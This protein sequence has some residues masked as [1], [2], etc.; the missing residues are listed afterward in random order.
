METKGFPLNNWQKMFSTD[1]LGDL[2]AYPFQDKDWY[3]K[4]LP[5]TVLYSALMFVLPPAAEVIQKGFAW[6]VAQRML[7]EG[8]EP[9]LPERIEWQAMAWDGLRWLLVSL[10]FNLPALLAFG[11]SA[12]VLL[13]RYGLPELGEA[14]RDWP[15]LTQGWPVLL[16]GVVIGMPLSI[17][18]GWLSNLAVMNMITHD[19]LAAAFRVGEWGRVLTANLGGFFRAMLSLLALALF[20]Q[21]VHFGLSIPAAALIVLPAL[22]G[23][24]FGVYRRLVSTALYAGLYRQILIEQH[25][26]SELP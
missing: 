22:I 13:A 21:V 4:L 11:A 15:G 9:R 5:L 6:R 25:T 12:E 8:G 23:G 17:L 24:F 20:L 26:K 16:V 3:R 19:S 1:A 14:A 7:A 10:I 18:G 2:L